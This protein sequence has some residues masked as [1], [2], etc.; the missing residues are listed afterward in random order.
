[1]VGKVLQLKYTDHNITN[2]MKFPDLTLRHYLEI[3][4]D[5]KTYLPIAKLQ[6]WDRGLEQVGLLNL[7]DIPHFGRIQEINICVNMVLRCVHDDYLW[8]G[9]IISIHTH[10]SLHES[11]D[12]S[13]MEN[14]IHYCSQIESITRLCQ[15]P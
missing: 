5:A 7:F 9:K 13:N 15:R 6:V 10:T 2:T 11:W 4:I 12:Y 14:I 1:M 8:L 3:K